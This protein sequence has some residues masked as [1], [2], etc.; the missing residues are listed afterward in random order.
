[1]NIEKEEEEA[2]SMTEAQKHYNKWLRSL[3]QNEVKLVQFVGR[4][5]RLQDGSTFLSSLRTHRFVVDITAF[6]HANAVESVKS[7]ILTSNFVKRPRNVPYVKRKRNMR[8]NDGCCKEKENPRK[9]SD[10][11]IVV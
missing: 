4:F 3:E 9:K 8:P 2:Q 10:Y 5:Y 1:L 11:E 7:G 6:V